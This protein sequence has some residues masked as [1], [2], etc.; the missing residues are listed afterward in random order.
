MENCKREN[1]YLIGNIMLSN[2]TLVC[3]KLNNADPR[4]IGIVRDR[5]VRT[6]QGNGKMINF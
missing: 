5:Y 3:A 6:D 1:T 2:I 4:W